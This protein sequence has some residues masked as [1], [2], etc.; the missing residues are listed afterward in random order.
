[1]KYLRNTLLMILIAALIMP[2]S[3]VLA[4][5]SAGIEVASGGDT[6]QTAE[7][8][9]NDMSPSAATAPSSQS[10]SNP[11]GEQPTTKNR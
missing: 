6:S 5:A 2:S 8:S 3:S 11:V 9:V 1:M 4:V 10:E 7:A